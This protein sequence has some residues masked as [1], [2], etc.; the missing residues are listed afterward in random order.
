MPRISVVVPIY[1]VEM[2]LPE[3]LRSLA[4]QTAR[5]LEVV[6]VDDGS[7]DG[8]AAIA[9]RFAARDRRFR[10]ITQANGGLG[11]ARNAG[12]AAATGELLAFVDS[13]DVVPGDAYE[14][15]AGALD[16]TGSDFASG[17]VLRLEDGRTSQ[18]PFLARTFAR[19]RLRTHVT[20]FEPLLAD[21]IACNKLWRRAFWDANALRFPEGVLHEDIPV[22]L[23][24]HVMAEAVDVLA[25]PV[26]QYRIR[27]D[28]GSITQK[29]LEMRALV[30]R[31]AAVEHVRAYLAEHGSR[32]L[33][34]RYDE[35]L[36]RDDLRLH[37]NLLA[38]A[39]DA[40][41]TC[42]VE[43]VTALL[44]SARRSLFR[45]LPAI[46]RLKWHL[47]LRER[48]D[49]LVEVLRFEQERTAATAPL[50]RRGR[51]YGDYPFRGDRE[52]AVPRSVYRL[53]KPDAELSLRATVEELGCEDGRLIVR[54]H[55]HLAGLAVE[56][57]ADQRVQLLAVRPGR[58]QR[59]RTRATPVRAPAR[60]LERPDLA[61]DPTTGALDRRWSGFE[62]ALAPATLGRRPRAA[63]WQLCV[64]VRTHGLRRRFVRFDLDDVASAQLPAGPGLM[65]RAVARPSRHI[66]VQV[67]DRWVAAHRARIVDGDVLELT[68][69]LRLA[70]DGPPAELEV[71]RAGDGWCTQVPLVRDEDAFTA[72]LPLSQLHLAPPDEVDDDALWQLSAIGDG[73]RVPLA[74]PGPSPVLRW[75][76]SGH[77]Q[78]LVRTLA[79]DA[80]IAGRDARPL[81]AA[82]EWTGANELE[83]DVRLRD[84]L[85]E[86][87]LVLMDWH[88]KRAHA[89]PL[90]PG[91]EEG[92][93]RARVPAGELLLVPAGLTP[94]RGEWR[95]YG[96]PLGS[97]ELPAMARV[98]LSAALA[99]TLPHATVLDERPFTLEP[100]PD[101]SLMLSVPERSAAPVRARG[102]R[103]SARA[104]ASATA[105]AG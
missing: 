37:L 64:Y 16:R 12:V 82:A 46:D 6:M 13:D 20:R 33:R 60:A 62:A 39:D 36:V 84:G 92:A 27:A 96:R 35:R 93:F 57:P 52:L 23:P 50:R 24:A 34:R 9:E 14:L 41:R 47:V 10:L 78:T 95:F 100:A 101:G 69:A 97:T 55:A 83:L 25:E 99:D 28:G 103:G 38:D 44:G 85:A 17:N 48:T 66:E 72:R 29:R 43:R 80:A 42:F 21:R 58:W 68:G 5:D 19:T 22:T 76:S 30:D 104:G 31:L 70:A 71:R 51:W 54:G 77:E 73:R 40:Y 86:R 49:E 102:A 1:D 91:D 4:A 45:D 74:L 79:G 32:G 98:R 8:S 26:Y 67:R 18:A 3:C 61:G 7:T 65:A 94:R 53:G 2:Y 88:R 63:T 81:I 87:E 75:W 90:L 56:S 89:F 15:L 11:H 105:P 59:L